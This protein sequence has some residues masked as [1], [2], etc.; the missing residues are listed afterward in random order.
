MLF[1][2]LSSLTDI[3]S[4][5]NIGSKAASLLWMSQQN[6][7]IPPTYVLPFLEKNVFS[8]NKIS[9]RTKLQTELANTLDLDKSYAVRSSANMEDGE[10]FSFAGQFT[11]KLNVVGLESISQ[12]VFDVL[13]SVDAPEIQTYL[14]RSNIPREELRMAVIIQEMVSPKISGVAFSRNPITGLDEVVVEVVNGSGE[15][16]MQDGIT[17]DR[18]VYKWGK[19]LQLPNTTDVDINSIKQV[20]ENIRSIEHNFGKPVDLEWVYNGDEVFYLQIREI[21]GLEN[22][23]IY[24]NRISRE[25]LPGLIK[26]LPWSVSVPIVNT[27]WVE[28]FRELIGE[29]AIDPKS[30]AKSFYYRAYFNMG[31]IRQL[32]EMLGLPSETLELLLGFDGG[33][34]KPRFRPGKATYR[35][36]PRLMLFVLHKLRYGNK[37]NRSILPKLRK[38]VEVYCEQSL[39]NL[40]DHDL[41]VYFQQLARLM[42]RIAYANI[43]IP[44]LNSIYN[45]LLRRQIAAAGI[46]Y[47]HF[48]VTAEF[49]Q[50]EEFDPNRSLVDLHNRL[51]K[52]DHET[53][54]TLLNQSEVNLD[55]LYS[56]NGLPEAFEQFQQKFGHLS[57]SGNDFSMK[58]WREDPA[59]VLKMAFEFKPPDYEGQKITWNNLPINYFKRFVL[60]PIY[61]RA[62]DFHLAREAISSLYVLGN[63]QFRRLFLELGKR[64]CSQ[65]ILSDPD[66]IFYLYQDEVWKLASGNLSADDVD[67][68]VRSRHQAMVDYQDIIVPEIIYGNS[69]PPPLLFDHELQKLKGIPS[70]GGYYQGKVC[71]VRT[72]SEFHKLKP[73]EILVIPYSDV[74]WTP[75]FSKAGAVVAEAGGILSHSS[76]VAREYQL[77]CVVS[78]DHATQLSDGQIVLV[79]GYRGEVILN[80]KAVD[81]FSRIA[82]SEKENPA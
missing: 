8:A 21:T 81:L 59:F 32:F 58:P 53:I 71:V 33:D 42:Q 49:R 69:E 74:A 35:L 13:M 50:I 56:L 10:A 26:P 48:D 77:P 6:L 3:D 34:E 82:N 40:D 30:L 18:F 44:I 38:N 11:T 79:D 25:V 1:P 41:K 14:E 7:N 28:L 66:D 65:G 15:Q 46:N 62:R 2:K 70:S 47:D 61:H 64:Y 57:A 60:K 22:I 80:D 29:F 36:L 75:L 73:G 37:F 78:V 43:V 51:E 45:L 23:A 4:V 52:L 63:S 16:L 55:L 20:V 24:S 68:L 72:A 17:P 54:T 39:E 9:F 76:I 27:A 31:V 19:W 67:K 5:N 12:A